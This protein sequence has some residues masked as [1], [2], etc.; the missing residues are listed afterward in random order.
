M[1]PLSLFVLTIL[2]SFGFWGAASVSERSQIAQFQ[3]V[4]TS[5]L[6]NDK[7]ASSKQHRQLRSILKYL[8]KRN[9]LSKLDEIT[10]LSM[11]SMY[12]N[13]AADGTKGDFGWL[14]A[15]KV[16]DSLGLTVDTASETLKN[17]GNQYYYDTNYVP[18]SYPIDGYQHMVSYVFWSNYNSKNAFIGDYYVSYNS[19]EMHVELFKTVDAKTVVLQLPVK[20]R[21]MA[22]SLKGKNLNNLDK[23]EFI[24]HAENDSLK[25]QLIFKSL[26]FSKQNDSIQLGRADTFLMLREK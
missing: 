19:E 8:E 22:L 5:V 4:Y 13:G 26:D 16:S 20:D 12:V 23:K 7:I 1:L 24:L 15:N 2:S 3:N 25:V 10:G 17:P 21:L 9:S 6:A 14:N 18:I 11:A